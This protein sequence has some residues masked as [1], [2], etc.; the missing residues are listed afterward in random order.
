MCSW[1]PTGD[2]TI[3]I[4]E[5]IVVDNI[6]LFSKQNRVSFNAI[7]VKAL[8]IA[9]SENPRVNSIIRF[10]KIYNRT[11]HAIFVH[12]LPLS[13]HDDLGGFTIANGADLS[14]HK[15]HEQ[16]E[17]EIRLIQ[18]QKD[19]FSNT[20]SFFKRMPVRLVRLLMNTMSFFL[21]KLNLKHRAF[22]VPQDPFGSIML[23]SVGSIGIQ[24]ALCPI[25]PYTNNSM[26]VSIGKI[27]DRTVIVNDE[28]LIKKVVTFGFCFDHRLID[29]IHF[30]LFFKSFNDALVSIIH[31]NTNI[32]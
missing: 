18:E 1:K 6:L 12:V 25:A 2:S 5:D 16:I 31:S 17:N 19:D 24:Q 20:K 28:I 32:D 10:G 21:Y 30:K 29:G 9:L 27:V 23:T 8:S 22:K 26:V 7:L 4:F 15:I 11:D 14:I 13:Q 3:G